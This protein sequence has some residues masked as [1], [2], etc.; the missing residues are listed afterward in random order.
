M[1]DNISE[2]VNMLLDGKIGAIFE[3]YPESGSRALGHRSIIANP[4]LRNGKDLVNKVKNREQFRPFAGSVLEDLSHEWFDLSAINGESPYMLYTVPVLQSKRIF[5]PAITHVDG[6]CRVQTVKKGTIFY[7]IINEFFIRTNI[8]ILLNT[9]FNLAGQPL[10]HTLE[11]AKQTFYNSELYFL[12][13]V[14]TNTLMS[15]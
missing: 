13:D 9:S 3:G 7:S 14:N 4:T 2:V 1:V 8:P 10:V 15:K 12:Y 11:D 6:S 5:I